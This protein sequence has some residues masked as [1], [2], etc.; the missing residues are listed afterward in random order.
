MHKHT[1]PFSSS[2]YPDKKFLFS[3]ASFKSALTILSDVVVNRSFVQKS[4]G[5]GFRTALANWFRLFNRDIA[6]NFLCVVTRELITIHFVSSFRLAGK[7]SCVWMHKEH[8]AFPLRTIS[9][10][11]RSNAS[12]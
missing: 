8:S 2:N 4:M 6:F 1:G 3:L 7:L 11:E 5:F 10:E 9:K 12:V